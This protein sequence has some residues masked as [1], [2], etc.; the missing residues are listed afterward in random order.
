MGQW[1][2]IEHFERLSTILARRGVVLYFR[3]LEQGNCFD[4]DKFQS[5]IQAFETV[6]VRT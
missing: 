2:G 5:D 6:I 3:G 1:Q 4:R